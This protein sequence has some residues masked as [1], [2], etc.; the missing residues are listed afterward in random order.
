[1]LAAENDASTGRRPVKNAQRPQSKSQAAWARSP[2]PRGSLGEFIRRHGDGL[3][4]SCASSRRTNKSE[5][6]LVHAREGA[7]DRP[8]HLP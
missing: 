5:P 6:T 1:M 7:W 4:A 8:R 3:F 2:A